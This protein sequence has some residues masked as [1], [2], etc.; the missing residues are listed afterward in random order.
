MGTYKE[1]WGDLIELAKRGQFDVIGHGCNCFCTMGAGIAPQMATAFGCNQFP[2]EDKSTTGDINKLGQID[3]KVLTIAVGNG[4]F[5]VIDHDLAIVNIYSQY[6]Y[7]RNHTDGAI[8]PLD[9][10]ALTLGLR[11]MNHLFKGKRVGLP[12]IGGGLAGGDPIRIVKI[13]QTEL[14]DCNVTLVKWSGP[15]NY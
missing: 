14:K 2:M 12:L 15:K 10:E 8:R 4:D 11:K 6:K 7:G 9:Y 5:D 13:I 3:W 1:V